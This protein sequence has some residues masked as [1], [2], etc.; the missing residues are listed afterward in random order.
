MAQVSIIEVN[1]GINISDLINEDIVGLVGEAQQELETAIAVAKK[2]VAL[3]EQKQREAQQ[4]IDKT[5]M[6]LMKAYEMLVQ[7]GDK[8]VLAT[9]ILA[10]T[11]EVVPQASAFALRMKKILK[12]EGNKYALVRKQINTKPHYIFLR[13][14]L[15]SEES[16]EPLGSQE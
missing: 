8:G 2:T 4:S 13:Y 1:L 9:D 7:A 14:N 11:A 6:T 10:V 16:I 3:K 15:P 12:S 5:H